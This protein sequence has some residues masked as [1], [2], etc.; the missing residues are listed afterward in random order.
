LLGVRGAVSGQYSPLREIDVNLRTPGPTPMPRRVAEAL[1]Q[2]MINHRGPEFAELLHEVTEGLK[3][4][5]QTRNDIILLT[6][7]GTGGLE[8]AV[9]NT[10][11]PGD[12]LLAV[13]I[14]NFGDRFA[15]IAEH[16]GAD[17]ERLSFPSGHAADP[18]AI[19]TRLAAEPFAGVLVTHNETSTGVT[20]D[21]AAIAEV[22]QAAR[23]LLVVD[24]V[25]SVGSIDVRTD[26]WGID[27]LVSGSQKG[28]M[29]PPGIAMVSVSP[30]AWE[31]QQTAR[32]PRYYW[33]FAAARKEAARG[34][35]PW[36]PG[37]TVLYGFR[38]ALRMIEEEGVQ[39]V[40]ERHRQIGAYT[41]AAIKDLGLRLVPVDERYAS[42]T[43]TAFYIPEPWTDATLAERLRVEDDV[44]LAGGQGELTGKI[45]R[46]G[47][48][49]YVTEAD[50]DQVTSAL[51]REL[52]TGAA[53]R[54]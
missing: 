10:F 5:F 19:A 38:E 34:Q 28:W 6:S 37:I 42:D 20:N 23:C 36:T 16:F 2:P 21:L 49:G 47:H 25:S 27:L 32:M 43:V 33:D 9:V 51:R 17:V 46:I 48:M 35:T 22:V 24:G 52:A 3:P 45:L 18:D 29:V 14:G 8:A 50:I 26:E 31:A 15:A 4:V 44:V 53:A 40:F 39:A 12:R 30:R 13:S 7:S 11:S 41:R 1:S 54:S